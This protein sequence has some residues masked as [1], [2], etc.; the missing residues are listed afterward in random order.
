M[1]ED[2][3]ISQKMAHA[4]TSNLQTGL[5]SESLTDSVSMGRGCARVSRRAASRPLLLLQYRLATL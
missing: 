5:I 4:R 3:T 2:D 1:D